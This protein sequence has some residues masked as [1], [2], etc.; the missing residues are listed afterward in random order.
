MTLIKI[1][2]PDVSSYT[3]FKSPPAPTKTK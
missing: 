1:I 3:V 2:L